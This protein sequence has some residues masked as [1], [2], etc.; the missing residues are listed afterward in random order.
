MA[1]VKRLCVLLGASLELQSTP[2]CGTTVRVLL[3]R[4]YGAP[5]A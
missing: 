2:G 4:H 3:P 5:P 1:I